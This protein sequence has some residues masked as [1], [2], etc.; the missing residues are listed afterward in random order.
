MKHSLRPP[1]ESDTN[2]IFNSW[3]KSYRSSAFAK[4]QCNTVFFDNYKRVIATIIDRSLISILCSPDDPNH[5]YGYI[6]YE[7][8]PGQNLLV[9][10][11]YVKHTY[12]KSGLAKELIKSA[13]KN[14]NPILTSHNTNV[15]KSSKSLVYIYDPYRAFYSVDSK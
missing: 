10:Y 11:V 5:L 6:V 7:D 12:R 4:D 1:T 2:F 8:L 14:S 13:R 9:H 15:C 3:L